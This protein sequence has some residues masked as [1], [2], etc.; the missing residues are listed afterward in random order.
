MNWNFGSPVAFPHASNDKG[1]NVGAKAV[2]SACDSRAME[3]DDHNGVASFS[4]ELGH[5]MNN[6]HTRII[7]AHA[8]VGENDEEQGGGLDDDNNEC[9]M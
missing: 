2:V 8:M 9:D 5:S 7:M 6:N 3:I 4:V 1:D